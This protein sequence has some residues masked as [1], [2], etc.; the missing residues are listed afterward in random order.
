[1]LQSLLQRGEQ[2]PP[3]NHR[4]VVGKKQGTN[5]GSG[6]RRQRGNRGEE[7]E[8]AVEEAGLRDEAVQQEEQQGIDRGVAQRRV[9]ER[10]QRAERLDERFDAVREGG[11]GR[12]D[13][14][15]GVLLAETLQRGERTAGEDVALDEDD[16][17]AVEQGEAARARA[18][19]EVHEAQRCDGAVD[20]EQLVAGEAGRDRQDARRA[21]VVAQ[22]S[23]AQGEGERGGLGGGETGEERE[24]NGGRG[25]LRKGVESAVEERSVQQDGEKQAVQ[26][27]V[28]MAAGRA[29]SGVQRVERG[30]EGLELGR[31]DLRH[32]KQGEERLQGRLALFEHPKH[33][34]GAL[35][36]EL[37]GKLSDVAEDRC[38]IVTR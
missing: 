29:G 2:Q 21:A 26:Q 4:G 11:G 38:H 35:T 6:L 9:E 7:A 23:E 36:S 10:E 14:E 16:E 19:R 32:G 13:G 22:Q 1:M 5:R 20:A 37:R 33:C 18:R 25:R 12:R 27:G 15:V 31:G 3:G 30:L 24:E 28:D 17:G 8:R 34:F